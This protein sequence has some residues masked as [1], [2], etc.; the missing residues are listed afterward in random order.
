MVSEIY[1]IGF[2]QINKT[3]ELWANKFLHTIKQSDFNLEDYK[4]KCT[5]MEKLVEYPDGRGWAK[6]INED[7]SLKVEKEDGSVISIYESM[8]SE[9]SLWK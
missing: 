4:V 6:D 3:A 1:G 2:D 5:T 7:G 9:V 8:I